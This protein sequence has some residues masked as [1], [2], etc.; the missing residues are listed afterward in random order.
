MLILNTSNGANSSLLKSASTT[1]QTNVLYIY[2]FIYLETPC[3]LTLQAN[4][5]N[6]HLKY[7]HLLFVYTD[8]KFQYKIFT[9]KFFMV[10]IIQFLVLLVKLFEHDM[11]GNFNGTYLI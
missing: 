8:A 7:G 1:Q 11:I 10:S 2:G 4:D 6:G 9:I 5:L 3:F